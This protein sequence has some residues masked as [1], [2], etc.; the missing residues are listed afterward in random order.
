MT[1]NQTSKDKLYTSDKRIVFWVKLLRHDKDVIIKDSGPGV[2]DQQAIKDIIPVNRE[3]I[4]RFISSLNAQGLTSFRQLGYVTKL[5]TL[6]SLCPKDFK[7][8][9]KQDIENV[10]SDL[11]RVK[12]NSKTNVYSPH[13]INSF[14]SG[15]KTFFRWMYDCEKG[16]PTPKIVSWLEKKKIPN[17]LRKEDL[18]T[19]DEVKRMCNATTNVMHKA[20]IMCL[21]EGGMRAGELRSMTIR[22]VI[23]TTDYEVEITVRGK[24]EK[25]QGDRIIYL[26]KSYNALKSWVDMHPSNHD[27]NA[28]LWINTTNRKGRYGVVIKHDNLNFIIKNLSKNAGIEKR[29]FPHLFRHS[30]ATELYDEVGEA[31]AKDFLGHSPDSA[32]ASVYKHFNHD[33]IRDAMRKNNG[34]SAGIKQEKIQEEKDAQLRKLMRLAEM[35]ERSPEIMRILES[36]TWQEKQIERLV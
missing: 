1:D 21:Y 34:I 2:K 7:E 5:K 4:L 35:I 20:L 24:M 29:V 10:M 28:P 31:I 32:M 33:N 6:S 18:L 12:P 36:K 13:S 3:H 11:R 14:I 16:D 19:F 22:D 30:R 25:T 26:Y 9:T 17:N 27:I 23:F 15:L 8:Y